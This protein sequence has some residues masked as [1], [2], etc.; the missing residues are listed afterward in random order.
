MYRAANY[1]E[2]F[3]DFVN[4]MNVISV[5]GKVLALKDL[6]DLTPLPH[7]GRGCYPRCR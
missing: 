1:L 6:I 7:R 4:A 2:K 3:R 5:G